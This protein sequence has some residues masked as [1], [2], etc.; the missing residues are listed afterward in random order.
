MYTNHSDSYEAAK[1]LHRASWSVGKINTVLRI[2]IADLEAR[3]RRDRLFREPVGA[4]LNL[5][6]LV[7]PQVARK[8]AVRVLLEAGWS[9]LKIKAVL[10]DDPFEQMRR[11]L[12]PPNLNFK[13]PDTLDHSPSHST[14][15]QTQ[16]QDEVLIR[17]WRNEAA[18]VLRQQGWEAW[19][20]AAVLRDV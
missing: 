17:E 15:S 12:E 8:D 14:Q 13:M 19:K 9:E 10:I 7:I 5:G 2:P 6:E 11:S 16:Q 3:L 4:G 18:H 20:I 1:V